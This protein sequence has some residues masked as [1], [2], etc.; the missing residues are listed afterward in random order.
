MDKEVHYYAIGFLAR[1]AGFTKQHALTIAYASQYVDNAT[2]SE[3]IRIGDMFFDPV[4]STHV[5]LRA[6]NWGIQKKI[7]IPFHFIP[8]RPFDPTLEKYSFV[9]QRNSLF[10]NM[11][12]R[13]ASLKSSDELSRLI[14][15]GIALHTLADTWA[16]QGF[17]G[18]E[19]PINDVESIHEYHNSA[20]QNPLLQNIYLNILPKV[21]HAQAG[22][23]PDTANLRWKYARAATKEE[24]ERDNPKEYLHA[25]ETIYRLLASAKKAVTAA[26]LPWKE[27]NSPIQAQFADPETNLEKRCGKW[28]TL[29]QSFFGDASGFNYDA[30]QWRRDALEPRNETEIEWD[31]F[32]PAEFG[33]L[34]FSRISGFYEMPWVKFHRAAL[35]QRNFVLEQLL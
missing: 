32:K 17:S 10:A 35:R 4:R 7:Y 28:R 27:I 18:R 21:G 34:A 16:H 29:Y 5:G 14:G 33:R 25:A 20:W 1:A 11:I 23:L 19:D 26:V 3:P 31:D 22:F 15:M 9:T 6:F 2:E 12:F 13:K 8:A 30:R 24:I